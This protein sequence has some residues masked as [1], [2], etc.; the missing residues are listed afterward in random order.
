MVKRTE[1]LHDEFS[2]ERKYG[3]LHEHCARYGEHN[4]INTK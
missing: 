3:V 2:L 1:V 4:I